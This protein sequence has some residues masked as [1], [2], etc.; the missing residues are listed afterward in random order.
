MWHVRI[1]IT[2]VV[3]ALVILFAI[4]NLR[5]TVVIRWFTPGSTGTPMSLT[6]ALLTA[7][8]LGFFTLLFISGFRELRLRRRCGRLEKQ[9]QAMREELDALRTASLEMPEEMPAREPARTLHT[10]E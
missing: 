5:E 7:Y 6:A 2:I 10:E 4:A 9:A 3:F 8:L 1:G